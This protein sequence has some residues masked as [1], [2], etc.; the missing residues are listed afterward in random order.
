MRH[1]LP[2]LVSFF[3]LAGRLGAAPPV[4]GVAAPLER[5]RPVTDSRP[6][7]SGQAFVLRAEAGE[8]ALAAGEPGVVALEAD[9][10]DGQHLL[11]REAG[12]RLLLRVDDGQRLFPR[13]TGLR[14]RVPP[15]APAV[16]HIGDASLVVQGFTGPSLRVEG[17]KGEVRVSATSTLVRIDT[18]SGAIDASIEGGALATSSLAGAQR[19][20]ATGAARVEAASTA[21]AIEARLATPAAVRLGTASG[22]ITLRLGS[23]GAGAVR[24]ASVS[25]PIEVRVAAG[26]PIAVAV[27]Q[28]T[29]TTDIPAAFVARPDGV[30]RFETE[31]APF[32]GTPLRLETFSGDIRVRME[33]APSQGPP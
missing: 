5:L 28:A 21:G 24:L 12:D 3:A 29:G 13:P 30:L 7:A 14:L 27:A 16:L 22:P 2:L 18:T 33:G 10:R 23:V 17:G 26:Q 6:L 32:E 1:A 31:S 19:L 11:W 20:E 15:D 4:A 8:V 25:G 9:L